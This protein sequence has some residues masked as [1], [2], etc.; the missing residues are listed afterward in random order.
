MTADPLD[1]GRV[2]VRDRTVVRNK[3]KN[4]GL[5]ARSEG[6]ECVSVEVADNQ[7]RIRGRQRYGAAKETHSAP[8][9]TAGPDI[10]SCPGKRVKGKH[11]CHPQKGVQ[12]GDQV[13]PCQV[14]GD[15]DDRKSD[16]KSRNDFDRYWQLK[17]AHQPGAHRG[18]EQGEGGAKKA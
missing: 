9:R 3:E 10:P 2:R 14:I 8:D 1:F 11:L 5:A 16:R 15:E 6:R 7:R 18:Q 12:E 4:I 17:Q 13:F